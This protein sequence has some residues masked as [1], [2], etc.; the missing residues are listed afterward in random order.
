[1]EKRR[2]GGLFELAGFFSIDTSDAVV[3][4]LVRLGF[5]KMREDK[6][7]L[8]RIDRNVYCL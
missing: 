4:L 5:F 2:H 6:H 1:M 8:K 7:W 3:V